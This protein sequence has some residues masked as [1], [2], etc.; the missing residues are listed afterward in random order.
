MKFLLSLPDTASSS[1]RRRSTQS[2]T[3]PSGSVP[4]PTPITL[5]SSSA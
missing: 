5:A 3:W 4:R 1:Q 2:L